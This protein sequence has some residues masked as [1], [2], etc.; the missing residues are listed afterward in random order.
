MKKVLLIALASVICF[1]TTGFNNVAQAKMFPPLYYDTNFKVDAPVTTE[2]EIKLTEIINKFR[3]ADAITVINAND[4]LKLMNIQADPNFSNSDIQTVLGN[5]GFAGTNFVSTN[6]TISY[7]TYVVYYQKKYKTQMNTKLSQFTDVQKKQYLALAYN[8]QLASNLYD[9]AKI[10]LAIF[11]QDTN[12]EYKY[13]NLAKGLEFNQQIAIEVYQNMATLAKN[14]G[15]KIVAPSASANVAKNSS[16]LYS[17]DQ[18]TNISLGL[19][20]AKEADAIIQWVN[21]KLATE[22]NIDKTNLGMAWGVKAGAYVYKKDFSNAVMACSKA[23][24]LNPSHAEYYEYRAVSKWNLADFSG[25]ISDYDKAISLGAKKADNYFN[26]ACAKVLLGQNDSAITDFKIVYQKTQYTN[27]AGMGALAMTYSKALTD[28]DGGFIKN[29]IFLD[30]PLI[31]KKYMEKT[32]TVPVNLEG[33]SKEAQEEA[34][35]KAKE[36]LDQATKTP[37]KSVIPV[38]CRVY[39]IIGRLK[40]SHT[41]VRYTTIAQINKIQDI[42]NA[43]PRFEWVKYMTVPDS[44]LDRY[45]RY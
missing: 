21:L 7:L 33:K 16:N 37:Q 44:Y 26:R 22:P 1:C 2:Q 3:Y 29:K 6:K 30:N 8:L 28:G 45:P 39:M 35:K 5:L 20:Q 31:M 38:G 23:I 4:Y 40:D 13:S 9:S 36:M 18:S 32:G 17:G 34:S 15:L 12:S 11:M 24:E 27:E 43:D 41:E 42:V 25:S 19:V 10:D 14:N